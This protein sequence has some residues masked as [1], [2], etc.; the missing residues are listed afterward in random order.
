MRR[1]LLLFLVLLIPLRCQSLSSTHPQ[2]QG[3]QNLPHIIFFIDIGLDIK[4][5]SVDTAKHGCDGVA[6]MMVEEA[7]VI[8]LVVNADFT[9]EAVY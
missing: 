5:H 1:R 8:V 6:D 4:P 7:G 9:A 2:I 3:T